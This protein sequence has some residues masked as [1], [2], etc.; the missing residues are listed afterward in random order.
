M[1]SQETFVDIP[2]GH[3]GG[4]EAPAALGSGC[5]G[6]TGTGT[7]CA[8]PDGEPAGATCPP[9]SPQMKPS[10]P[11]PAISQLTAENVTHMYQ[12]QHR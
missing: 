4:Q 12:L 9:S 1:I 11:H 8:G 3:L 10:P 5:Q 2:L 6:N 7:W